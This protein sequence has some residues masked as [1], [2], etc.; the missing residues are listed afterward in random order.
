MLLLYA[1]L[2]GLT[3]A[4]STTG[5]VTLVW[6]A[7]TEPDVSTYVIQAASQSGGPYHDV[8][9]TTHTSDTVTG[10]TSGTT[11]FFIVR[12][13]N[14]GGFWSGPSNEVRVTIP[15]VITP[16]PD[17]CA[18]VTGRYAVSIFLTSLLKTGSGGPG[19][20]ARLLFQLAS[21]GAPITSVGVYADG[22]LVSRLTKGEDLTD[23]PGSW[24]T[25]PASGNYALSATAT[26]SQGCTKTATYGSPLVVP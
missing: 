17:D 26:N 24:F 8:L 6:D 2:L 21:P 23:D 3:V 9:Q 10:L 12:A 16:P 22:G 5:S 15:G 11:Y 4:S 25:M 20:R 18:P 1:L 19:S 14:S 7:N 13:I